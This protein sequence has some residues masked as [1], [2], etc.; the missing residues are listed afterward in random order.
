[1][2]GISFWVYIFDDLT[3]AAY[4]SLS[5]EQVQDSRKSQL[6]YDI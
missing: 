1:M 3:Y 6:I 5:F 4:N 2:A